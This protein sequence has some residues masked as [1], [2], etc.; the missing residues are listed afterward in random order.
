MLR[1]IGKLLL[2]LI[3]LLGVAVGILALLAEPVPDH[4]FFDSPG[5]LVMAHRGGNGLWP[6]NTLYAF[7]QAVHLGV[8][9]LETDLHSTRDSVLVVIHDRTVD[10][11]TNGVGPVQS[12]TLAELKTL[13]AG[14]TW[15]RDGGRTFP[16]RG[17]GL[18][19]PTLAEVFAAFPDTRVNIEVKQSRPSVLTALCRAIRDHGKTDRVL[20]ASASTGSLRAFRR[21]CPEIATSAG[22][23]EL[24]AFYALNRIYLG[25]IYPT[26]ARALQVPDRIRILQVVT[27]RFVQT[28]HRQN[29]QV[30]AW[31]FNRSEESS[32]DVAVTDK[33]EDL[34]RLLDLGVDGI[35][36]DRPDRLLRLLGR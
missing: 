29:L 5:V 23:T 9:V 18:T 30:H 11:T 28:A 14:Y 13:D 2:G 32:A 27:P 10:R 17:R 21:I 20:V 22:F 15:T 7:E 1:K 36:T 3:A 6:E 34:Q 25:G 31:V 35:I 8:D 24:L 26:S 12:L 16:F 4:P 33:V 19:V